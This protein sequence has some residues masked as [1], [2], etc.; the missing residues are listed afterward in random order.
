MLMC[1][2]HWFALPQDLRSQIWAAYREGQEITKSPSREYL[3]V[4]RKVEAFVAEKRRVQVLARRD[5]DAR[6]AQLPL[7]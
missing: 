5:R 6:D 2:P 7:L 3:E 4:M 1:R